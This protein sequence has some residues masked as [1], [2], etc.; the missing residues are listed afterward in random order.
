MGTR[1]C[2]QLDPTPATIAL[3]AFIFGY[4]G[5]SLVTPHT[6]LKQ[7]WWTDDR[8]KAKLTD[9]FIF[10][11][12]RGEERAFLNRPVG[13]GEGL[14]DDTYMD[15]IK[16]RARRLFL[17]LAEIGV[18]DQIFG[19]IDDSW[20]DDDL[21]ISLD[22]VQNLD[23]AIEN[24][25]VLNRKFYDTQF[26]YLLR[27]LDEGNHIDYGPNEHIPMEHVSTLPP[28]VSLQ[29]WDRIHF[30]G[31]P[32]DVYMRRKY[33]LVDK[34]SGK[35]LRSGFLKDVRRAQELAHEHIAP[36]WAS[37]TSG[38]SGYVV[39][40][41]VGEHTLATFI[42]HR[43]PTSFQR[44]RP[45]E[46]PIVLCEW[47]HCLADA[48][49]SLHHRGAAHTTIRPSNILIDHS[50]RIAFADVGALQTFQRGK[51]VKHA[52]AYEY[53]APETRL[54]QAPFA[55][56]SSPPISSKSAFNR[57][58][59]LSSSTSGSST[60]SS[61]GSSTRS[62]S[63]CTTQTSPGSPPSPP[64]T[65]SDSITTIAA[66]ISPSPKSLTSTRNFSRHLT[67]SSINSTSTASTSPT[68][69][70]H[71]APTLSATSSASSDEYSEAPP[72][73]SDIF[74]LGCA[75]L[76]ITTFLLRGKTN[77]FVKFRTT[78]VTTPN[79][80]K[81]RNDTSFHFDLAKLYTWIDVLK[82][83]SRKM[84]EQIYRGVPALLDLI[85][86]MLAGRWSQRPTAMQVRDRIQEILV[87]ECEVETLCCAGREWSTLPT[88][89]YTDNT[90]LNRFFRDSMSV[91]TGAPS[92]RSR[93]ASESVSSRKGS[94]GE[95]PLR[96]ATA[97]PG[98]SMASLRSWKGRRGS[99]AS[100]STVKVSSWRRA[101]SRGSTAK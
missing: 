33:S 43:N 88:S 95:E 52:E 48:L 31:R 47:M 73:V 30:P 17:I 39:S 55:L 64:P 75:F 83:D 67:H 22:D 99:E 42:N 38:D 6:T 60:G 44:L 16:E 46:K 91:A 3:N 82:E 21:P 72:E 8:I 92:A 15:W 87:G 90:A 101:F 9:N 80:R 89:N 86:A 56:A 93:Q 58:R 51:K 10:S 35:D 25:E 12:L 41:F 36:V 37:Y 1:T 74:S 5:H 81:A 11:K 94:G 84:P 54:A 13:F 32:D 2:A 49:A 62:N 20:D 27:E 4:G 70:I 65:R 77:D 97:R 69:I 14:T 63:C 78:R 98:S 40:D 18:P 59:K 66:S 53:A 24:D 29:I 26:I 100:A 45:S 50:N 34:E 85:A 71:L 79:K 68:T 7:L 96:P 76:D 23:L 19:C 28:A 57:L 61:N